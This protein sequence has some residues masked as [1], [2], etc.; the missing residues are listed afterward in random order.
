[1][2]E[3]GCGPSHAGSRAPGL[4]LLRPCSQEVSPCRETRSGRLSVIC[5]AACWPLQS[6]RPNPAPRLLHCSTTAAPRQQEGRAVRA[7]WTPENTDYLALTGQRAD[8]CSLWLPYT[9]GTLHQEPEKR[10]HE[11][12]MSQERVLR[13]CS[14]AVL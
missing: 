11:A 4:T 13:R 2:P 8:P 9:V 12:S 5:R 6:C 3:P 1:M 14:K 7:D 10:T